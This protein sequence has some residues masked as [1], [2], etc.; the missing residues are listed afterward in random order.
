VQEC[1]DFRPNVGGRSFPDSNVRQVDDSRERSR[2]FAHGSLDALWFG[3]GRRPNWINAMN[4]AL[5]RNLERVGEQFEKRPPPVFR[6]AI[7]G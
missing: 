6:K 2:V 5:W 3:Y 4:Q 1:D 7:G